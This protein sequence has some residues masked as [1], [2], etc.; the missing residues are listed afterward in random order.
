MLP[1]TFSS[2]ETE[3][4]G[5]EESCGCATSRRQTGEHQHPADKY[6][7][8]TNQLELEQEGKEEDEDVAESSRTN[9]ML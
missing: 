3:E 8:Q 6:S 7:K 1:R 2:C 5:G 9:E 4:A